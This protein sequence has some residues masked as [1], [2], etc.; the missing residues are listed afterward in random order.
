MINHQTDN[1]PVTHLVILRRQLVQTFL[2]DV[3]PIQILDEDHDVHTERDNDRM[4]LSVV[5][6]ISLLMH[7]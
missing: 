3:V 1:P 7:Q 6:S 4:N 5:S 2:D